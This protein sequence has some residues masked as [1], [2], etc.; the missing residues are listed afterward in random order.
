MPWKL[1][2]DDL[3]PERWFA[4]VLPRLVQGEVLDWSGVPEASPEGLEALFSPLLALGLSKEEVAR[5]LGVGTMPEALR[6][7]ALARLG[8]SET[9]L[10]AGASQRDPFAQLQSIQESFRGYAESFVEPRNPRIADFLRKGVEEED[11]LWREPS[12]PRKGATAW[13]KAWTSSSGKASC[14]RRSA[15]S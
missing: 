8:L 7:W 14:P 10:R 2:P 6:A 9:S 3:R 5:R 12:W 1:Q 13:A 11:L 15:L 4:Q